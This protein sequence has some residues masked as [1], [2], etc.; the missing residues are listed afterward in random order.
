[1]KPASRQRLF[2]YA[3][4]ARKRLALWLSAF[5][6]AGVAVY[7]V[8]TRVARKIRSTIGAPSAARKA[9]PDGTAPS[10]AT[11]SG[12]RRIVVQTPEVL[13]ENLPAFALPPGAERL[14]EGVWRCPVLTKAVPLV[15]SI[16]GHTYH[17]PS[18]RWAK[19]IRDENR[20]CFASTKTAES[21]GYSACN[22]CK[23]A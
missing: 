23:P 8:G 21:R 18:C 6:V 7:Y 12:A 10:A 11:A 3:K 20:I 15:G 4:S 22:T 2:E 17:H 16:E 1:M 19:N 9:T 13:T 5:T 14:D